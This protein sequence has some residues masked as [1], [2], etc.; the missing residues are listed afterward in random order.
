MFTIFNKY[1]RHNIHSHYKIVSKYINILYG[2]Y[3]PIFVISYNSVIFILFTTVIISKHTFLYMCYF[4]FYFL[5]SFVIYHFS[6]L[7]YKWKKRTGHLTSKPPRDQLSKVF[8]TKIY[9]KNT[10]YIV[11]GS[12]SSNSKK[13]FQLQ[14]VVI[15]LPTWL[16]DYVTAKDSQGNKF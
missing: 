8:V 13:F 2:I 6:W 9:I 4:C 15:N 10:F 5:F 7:C 12:S 16:I 11:T 3:F 14:V 1:T